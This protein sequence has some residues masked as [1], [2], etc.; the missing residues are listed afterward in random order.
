MSY[1]ARVVDDR[2]EALLRAM[3]GV[4]IEGARACGKTSTGLEHARSEVRL[5]SDPAARLAELDPASLLEGDTPRLVDEWQLAPHLWNLIRHEIDVRQRKGQFILSGSATPSDDTRRHSGAGRFGRIRMRT[6]TLW[7]AGLSSGDV[8]LADI[9]S[10]DALSNVRSPLSYR[11]LARVAVRGGWPGVVAMEDQDAVEFNASYVEDVVAADIPMATGVHRDPVR[12][13]RLLTSLARLLSQEAS[14]RSLASDVAADGGRLDRS[15]V[16]HYLDAL[17][18]V[19]VLEELPAWSVALRSRSRLRQSAKVHLTDPALACALLG[20]SPERL[21]ANPE[22]FGQVF[23][24]L[25]IRDLRV[26]AEARRGKVYHYRDDTGLEIDAV[27]EYPGS[28]AA[29]EIKLGS[30]EVPRAESNLLK[31]RDDRVDTE[32]VGQPAFL[33]V[34]TGTEAGYTLPSGV[35]VIP[36]GA[37]AP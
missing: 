8:S 5:D 17:A 12:L 34:V 23:E 16:R 6:L 15:T 9:S 2:V 13:R 27:L 25:A 33:A 4:V 36:L 18:R 19:L 31:L 32:L 26:Y 35:H 21:A 1:M 3:G 10:A 24:S 7:E 22:Y 37:L 11:E 30:K 14:Q 20:A 29:V 28:W